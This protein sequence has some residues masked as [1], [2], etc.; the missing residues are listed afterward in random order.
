M[1]E[2]LGFAETRTSPHSDGWNLDMLH[3]HQICEVFQELFFC[4][5]DAIPFYS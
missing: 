4:V 1:L 5:T 2:L 3:Q